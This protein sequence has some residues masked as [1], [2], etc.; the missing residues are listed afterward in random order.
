MRTIAIIPAR[1]GS[2][3]LPG[4][5][6]KPFLGKPLLAWSIEAAQKSGTIDHIVVSTDGDEALEIAGK[7]GAEGMRRPAELASDTAL[8]KDAVLHVLDT[9]EARGDAPFDVLVLLQPT[10]P[11]RQPE[12]ILHCVRKLTDD[13][14]DSSATFKASGAHPSRVWSIDSGLAA[15]F[16]NDGL[17]WAPRQ[18]VAPVYALNGAVYAVDVAGFRA[19][20]S[21]AFLFGKTAGVIMEPERSIDID[22][23]HD[24][25]MAEAA[26]RILGLDGA[27]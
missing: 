26:A 17:T 24:F 18:A 16:L 25:R 23:L 7:Y 12:D 27:Q 3:G 15:P 20:P 22:T 2:K 8:P 5:N 11:L 9:L 14:V 10:S 6:T 13:G 19:E 21:S 1:A 4:K